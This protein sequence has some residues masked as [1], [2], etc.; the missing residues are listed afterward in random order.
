MVLSSEKKDCNSCTDSVQGQQYLV[1]AT[2]PTLKIGSWS[3]WKISAIGNH[4]IITVD[5]NKLIDYNDQ[6]MSSQLSSGSIAMY[7]ED[8][9]A[10]FD[11][12][13]VT[14]R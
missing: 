3:N 10:Q 2:S 13:Y 9:S 12:V 11:N 14:P 7:N 6:T 1:T 8:S 5:G 4:I